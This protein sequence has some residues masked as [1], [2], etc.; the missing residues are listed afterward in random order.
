M[1]CTDLHSDLQSLLAEYDPS[2]VVFVIDE[3]VK[4][5]PSA[6]SHQKSAFSLSVTEEGKSLATVQ[7]IW[8]FLIERRITRRGVIVAVGGGVVTDLAGFAAAT[9]QRGIAYVNVPTTLLAM[10]DASTGGKTGFNYGGLKNCIGAFHEPLATLIYPPFL[11]TLPPRE[12]LSGYA[13]MLKTGLIEYS[14]SRPRARHQPSAISHQKSEISKVRPALFHR[15]LQYD[16]ETMPIDSLTPLI[17]DCIGI[18]GRIVAADPRERN[19]RKA[20]N[21]GHTFGH[22]LEEMAI[23]HHG[24]GLSHQKSSVRSQILPHGYAVLYGLIAELYLSVTLAGCPREPL[25]Q[26]TSLMLRY[27]G[28]PQCACSDRGQLIELMHRDK[29]NERAA[30]INC[31]LIRSVGCPL[32]NQHITDAQAAEAWDYIFSL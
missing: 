2:Q 5:A 7:Q 20:L 10:V 12:M 1:I 4:H 25:Q 11:A 17:A 14:P 15:L 16:L 8:D 28:R 6:V 32:T 19:L 23:R 30:D 13:E 27:Y 26:L 31:T 21:L 3:A 9:Y 29:K 24:H 18:K 22:A